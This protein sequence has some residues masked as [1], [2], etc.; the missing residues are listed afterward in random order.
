MQLSYLH[1]L[2]TR[3]TAHRSLGLR[4][5]Y[6]EESHSAFFH[7]TSSTWQ[8]SNCSGITLVQKPGKF[9]LTPN[10]SRGCGTQGVAGKRS[11]GGK[12]ES[13]ISCASSPR[14][15]V[16]FMSNPL[17][18]C[19]WNSV[20]LKFQTGVFPINIIVG[21]SFLSNS[22]CDL[23]CRSYKNLFQIHLP[24]TNPFCDFSDPILEIQAVEGY[25]GYDLHF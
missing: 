11:S 1:T 15:L 23:R 25:P 7:F 24:V 18:L 3:G 17:T 22:H 14:N 21:P 4:N 10:F 13:Y 5:I 20:S 6:F 12:G 16:L 2:A 9:F 19:A 8:S